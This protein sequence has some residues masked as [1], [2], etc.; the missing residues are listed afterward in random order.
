MKLVAIYFPKNSLPYIFGKN[1]EGQTLNLCGDYSFIFETHTHKELLIIKI[2][3]EYNFI[4]NFWG[5]NISLIN[6]VVGKNGI[7]KTTILRAINT[8]IDFE[9]HVKCIYIFSNN[10]EF[11]IFNE[12]DFLIDSNFNFKITNYEYFNLSKL[13]YSPIIEIGRC[14]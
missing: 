12:T 2:D 14:F 4:Q 9:K 10:N 3:N 13:Y 7:G 1:H 8:S 11:F 6:A 5:D